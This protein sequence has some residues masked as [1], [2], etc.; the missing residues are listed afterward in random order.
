M[1][2]ED[3][4]LAKDSVSM[5]LEPGASRHLGQFAAFTLYAPTLSLSLALRHYPPIAL[6]KSRIDT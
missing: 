3:F 1:N 2:F 4:I 6:F 5:R